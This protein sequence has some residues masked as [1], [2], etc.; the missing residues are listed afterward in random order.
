VPFAN[1]I[2]CVQSDSNTEPLNQNASEQQIKKIK[3]MPASLTSSLK[4][5]T[6]HYFLPLYKRLLDCICFTEQQQLHILFQISQSAYFGICFQ[7]LL[8]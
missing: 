5:N 8:E 7:L 1:K 3:E 2:V 4:D 6:D